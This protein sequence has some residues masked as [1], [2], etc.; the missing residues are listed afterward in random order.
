MVAVGG[1]VRAADADLRV[2]QAAKK[3]DLAGVRTLIRAKA[4]VSAAEVDGS[5]ALLWA[6]YH[7]N[8]EATRALLAAGAKVN[9]ANRYGVTPLL[10]ASR[11]GHMGIIEALVKAGAD[12]HAPQAEGETPLMAAAAAGSADAVRLFVARGA[13]VNAAETVQNQ[14]ALMWAAGEGHLDVVRV[15]LESGANPNQAGRVTGLQRIRGDGG[16]MWVD[17]T[18]GGLTPLMF[19]ARHGHAEIARTLVDAGADVNARNPDGL[20]ALI[21][22]V[23]ND[24]LDTAGV[25]LD[26]GADPNDGAMYEAVNLHNLRTNET[27]GEAT[28]PRP[29]NQNTLTPLDVIGK[30]LD[31]GGDPMRNATHTLHADATGQP[32]P[33]NQSAFGR[34]L[35]AQDVNALRLLIAKGANVNVANETG[36]ALM[37]LMGG[38]GRFGGG[39]GAQPAAFRFAGPRS[40]PESVKLLL[41]AGADVH[42]TRA[43]GDT[44]LHVAA[45]AGNLPVIQMLVDHGAKLDARNNGGFTPLDSAMGR[46]A[47]MPATGPPAR[48]GGGGGGRGGGPQPQPQAIALLQK[49]MGLPVDPPSAAPDAGGRGRG[50]N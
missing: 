2:V 27:I 8:V 5:T 33:V 17:F 40:A 19:A 47:P 41:D 22:A 31:R 18:S 50:G 6:A 36:T 37:S 16:R 46:Q 26:K 13:N 9:V 23:I 7:S 48:G 39:F 43:N 38:G 35:Q 10:Q 28:R 11:L 4:D 32:Q 21:I 34:A 15:L 24:R 49:L 29:R 3:D 44:A 14:T 25:L 30:M 42:A 45:A 12:V 20:T 1:L